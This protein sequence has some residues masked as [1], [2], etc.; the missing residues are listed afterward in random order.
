MVRTIIT[1]TNADIQLHIREEYIGKPIEITYLALEEIG[2]SLPNK[3]TVADFWGILSDKTATD[4]RQQVE[5]NRN[6]WEE[7][8]G[9]QF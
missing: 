4:L 6:E 1:P 3:K 5:D 2:Q 8:L 9:K 7:R